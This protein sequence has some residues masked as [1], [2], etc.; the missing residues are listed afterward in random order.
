MKSSK[1]VDYMVD[2]QWKHII[3]DGQLFIVDSQPS[4]SDGQP[5]VLLGFTFKTNLKLI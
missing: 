4:I 1:K 3:I 2:H 5:S